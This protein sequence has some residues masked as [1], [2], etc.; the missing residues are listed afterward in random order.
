MGPS[1]KVGG[2]TFQVPE[3]GIHSFMIN[4]TGSK[5]RRTSARSAENSATGTATMSSAT[6]VNLYRS[7]L[8]FTGGRTHIP[9]GT[10]GSK[11]LIPIG[12]ALS[13]RILSLSR[14]SKGLKSQCLFLATTKS[15]RPNSLQN[16]VIKSAPLSQPTSS[17]TETTASSGA[18]TTMTSFS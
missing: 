18:I 11:T 4:Q 7:S 9:M 14:T 16:L 5:D 2:R 15:A 8:R 13:G 12:S 6:T 17:L 10:A 1:L 3:A